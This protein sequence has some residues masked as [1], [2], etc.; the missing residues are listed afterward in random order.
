MLVSGKPVAEIADA[1]GY[2][3]PSS[4]IAMFKR[5]FRETPGRYLESIRSSKP[6]PPTSSGSI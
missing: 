6:K 5:A 2:A 3:T 1:L 4:F